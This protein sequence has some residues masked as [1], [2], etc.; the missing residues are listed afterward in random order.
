MNEYM[1]LFHHEGFPKDFIPSP[2]MIQE[3]IAQWQQWIGEIA[4]K[5]KF[6]STG[7]LHDGGKVVRQSGVT[8]GP[9]VEVKEIVGGFLFLKADSIEEAQE[10]SMGCPVLT[11]GGAVEVREMI[12]QGPM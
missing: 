11:T 7:R 8:D 4:A 12:S 6:L 3:S 10:L 5:G 1:L 2:E 9:F